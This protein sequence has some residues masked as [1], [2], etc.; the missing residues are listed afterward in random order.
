[1]S[2]PTELNNCTHE[3][4]TGRRSPTL[5]PGSHNFDCSIRKAVTLEGLSSKSCVTHPYSITCGVEGKTVLKM[6][7]YSSLRSDDPAWGR[8]P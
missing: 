7:P 8:R 2:R 5:L 4:K 6:N 3:N 1:M